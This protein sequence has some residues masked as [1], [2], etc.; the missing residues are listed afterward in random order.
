MRSNGLFSVIK[1]KE[2]KKKLGIE[3]NIRFELALEY[4]FYF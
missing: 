3:P 1:M 4:Q 2:R